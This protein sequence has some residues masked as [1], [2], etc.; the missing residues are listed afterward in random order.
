CVFFFQADDG[1][2]DVHVTGV[3]TCALPIF[4][5]ARDQIG[6]IPLYIGWDSSESLYVA[7]ELKALEGICD[8]IE[9]FKP[10]HFIDSAQGQHF[11]QDRKSGV[12]GKS[13]RRG[14]SDGGNKE[15]AD[16]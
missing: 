9:T 4:L 12:E 11:Q 3:Q 16:A 10:G 2:R 8:V 7:S 5:I 1:I 6:I 14:G 13:G 15:A